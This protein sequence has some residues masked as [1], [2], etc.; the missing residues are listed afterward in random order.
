MRGAAGRYLA[1]L[2]PATA[3]AALYAQLHDAS[4]VVR[5]SAVDALDD[6]GL[7][8]AV[9]LIEPL[10]RDRHPHVRQAAQTALENLKGRG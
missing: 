10:L 1:G 9:P 3:L 4:Y 8:A 5:E 6:A 2:W 7:V